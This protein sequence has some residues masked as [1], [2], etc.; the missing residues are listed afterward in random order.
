MTSPELGW[1]PTSPLYCVFKNATFYVYGEKWGRLK[2]TPVFLPNETFKNSNS[3]YT[4]QYRVKWF[5]REKNLPLSKLCQIVSWPQIQ[6]RPQTVPLKW[7]TTKHLL[8]NLKGCAWNK[9]FSL[10]CLKAKLEEKLPKIGLIG[11]KQICPFW[12]QTTFE[13]YFWWLVFG[14]KEGIWKLK[15]IY[16]FKVPVIFWKWK[17]CCACAVQCALCMRCLLVAKFVPF[18]ELDSNKYT[19]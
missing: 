5:L 17:I 16:M 18:L 10:L 19:W 6:T 11:Q 9:M 12:G 7:A 3:V 15:K 13:F 14:L 4:V 2:S 8:Y 1:S